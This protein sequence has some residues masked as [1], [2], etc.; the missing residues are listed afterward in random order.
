MGFVGL[1]EAS[2]S[3]IYALKD[4][5]GFVIFAVKEYGDD[6][7][8]ETQ[9]LFTVKKIVREAGYGFIIL[10]GKY[11]ERKD[12]N[13]EWVEFPPEKSVFVPAKKKNDTV[14]KELALKIAD[15][16]N[17][18]A[19]FWADGD[20][21]VK[22]VDVKT[23]NEISASLKKFKPDMP[24]KPNEN[25]ET[26]QYGYS[27]ITKGRHKNRAFVFEHI[28]YPH[29]YINNVGLA[30]QGYDCIL[31]HEIVEGNIVERFCFGKLFE[32]ILLNAAY[33]ISPVGKIIRVDDR[34]ISSIIREP[35]LFGLSREEIEAIYAKHNERMGHEGKAREEIIRSIIA[36]GYIRIRLY[37]KQGFWSINVNKLNNRNKDLIQQWAEEVIKDGGDRYNLV[38][39]LT[40]DDLFISRSVD[41]ISKYALY[42][43]KS[44]IF[45]ERVLLCFVESFKNTD[46]EVYF[47]RTPR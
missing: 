43:N 11:F 21:G 12:K 30:A 7:K 14:L 35:E 26:N 36:K 19:I 40:L 23:G 17:Q 20:G 16:Y 38:N 1:N 6:D 39:I 10:D 9:K 5:N 44:E 24:L 22:Y 15:T 13:S 32:S 28:L 4:K 34:H 2:L 8:T 29:G 31:A 33:W 37:A 46:I 47:N 18:S 27:L 45:G 3:R 25:T 42:E 41:D